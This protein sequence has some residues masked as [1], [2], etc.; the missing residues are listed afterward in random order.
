[1]AQPAPIQK[2][3]SDANSQCTITAAPVEDIKLD[4]LN[5]DATVGPQTDTDTPDTA[6]GSDQGKLLMQK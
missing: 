6:I 2:G 3:S 5:T 1:M 4:I